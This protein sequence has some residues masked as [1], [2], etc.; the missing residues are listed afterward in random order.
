MA[1][2]ERIDTPNHQSVQTISLPVHIISCHSE[3]FVMRV[4]VPVVGGQK[5]VNFGH[6]RGYRCGRRVNAGAAESAIPTAAA[7]TSDSAA[8]KT[9]T[10]G[11]CAPQ[12]TFIKLAA[13]PTIAA[14][15]CTAEVSANFTIATQPADKPTFAAETSVSASTSV[16]TRTTML[17]T[18]EPAEPTVAAAVPTRTVVPIAAEPT[19]AAVVPTRTVVP[20]A[21]EP[22]VLAAVPTRTAVPIAA[23][24]TVA[25][26][27]TSVKPTIT[28]ASISATSVTAITADDIGAE[29]DGVGG[30]ARSP[31][32]RTDPRSGLD[33]LRR[34]VWVLANGEAGL[35]GFPR[36]GIPWRDIEDRA[37]R[38]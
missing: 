24:P 7:T 17:I 36:R 19:V 6:I 26:V 38:V 25:A 3:N 16:P 18:A 8:S 28:R 33:V 32:V 12:T 5:R 22:T 23:E 29:V 1:I 37:L 11:A 20:I 4:K 9:C 13:E 21:A 27:P 14:E 31:H 15:T 2:A 30:L 10:P 34:P 35:D